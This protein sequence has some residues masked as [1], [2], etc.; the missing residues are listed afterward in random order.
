[1]RHESIAIL[2]P[3][4]AS[5]YELATPVG[6]WGSGRAAVDGRSPFR[7][8]V[9]SPLP[10]APTA[11]TAGLSI[12]GMQSLEAARGADLVVVPTWPVSREDPTGR[13]LDTEAL[14]G[15]EE[16]VSLLGQAS[17]WGATVVGLCLGAFAVAE[18][19]LLDG[20]EAVTHWALREQFQERFSAV[21]YA[22]DP[23]YVD[24]GN[25]VTS[26]GSAAALDC[27]LHLVR[28]SHGER[29]A[30]QVARSMVTPPHRDGGQTQ[31]VPPPDDDGRNRLSVTLAAAVAYANDNLESLR[32][33]THLAEAVGTSRRSLERAF[34]AELSVAPGAWLLSQRLLR[35][36]FV[37]ETTRLPIEQAAAAAGFGS[38]ASLQRHFREQLATTPR[39]YRLAFGAQND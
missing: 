12:A 3:P 8:S 10:G 1:M 4:F 15:C 17:A 37:L 35:A 5:L 7:V 33:V 36:R 19:G 23:L 27:C 28:R 26:A 9:C 24:N 25:V 29:V 6:V 14:R 30:T 16:I 11:S 21:T 20:T 34:A 31:F 13:N 18:S 38:A 39:A 2:V 22:S 32:S